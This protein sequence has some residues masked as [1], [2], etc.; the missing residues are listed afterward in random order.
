MAKSVTNLNS[1]LVSRAG[2][3]QGRPCLKGTGITVHA[4]AAA[5]LL[6]LSAEEIC[7]QNPDLDASLF[8]AALA[9]YFANRERVEAEIEQDRL[10][11][12]KLAAVYPEG[13][14]PANF[15]RG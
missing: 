10:D 4:V 6:G 12:E 14:T 5:Y 2:Y 8:Y 1:L 11:G 7:R 9:Y 13:V 3:R 15:A